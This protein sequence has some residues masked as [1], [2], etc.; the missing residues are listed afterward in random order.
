MRDS[1]VRISPPRR[2]GDLP[3]MKPGHA[4][5]QGFAESSA[6]LGDNSMR[7]PARAGL[8]GN[9]RELA[10]TLADRDLVFQDSEVSF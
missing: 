8:A 7:R 5:W 3:A 4:R 6:S 2:A 1:I 10:P 9:S